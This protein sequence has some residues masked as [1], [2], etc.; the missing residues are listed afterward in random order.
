[1]PKGTKK[2][3]ANE[4]LGEIERKVKRETYT[5]PRGMPTFEKVAD[6]YL[7][8]REPDIRHSTCLGY[9]GHIKNH[10][11]PEFGHLKVNKVNFEAIEQFKQRCLKKAKK[12]TYEESEPDKARPKKPLTPA[13]VL[14]ILGTLSRI[15]TYA[16]RMGKIDHNPA[17]EVERPRGKSLHNEEDEI[18]VLQPGEIRLL[19]DAA[20]NQGERVLFVAAVLTG[21]R[22]G[23]LLGLKWGDIDWVNCQVCVRRTYNYR[24]FYKPKSKTSRRRVDLAP[25]LVSELKRW[26]LACP[27][28]DLDLVF[29]T[30]IGTPQDAT[31]MLRRQFFPALRRAGLPK[32][33]FQDLRHTYASLLIDQGEYPKYIQD[34]LGHSTI[35]LTMDIY[36]H[37]MKRV[38]RDAATKLGNTVLGTSDQAENKMVAKNGSTSG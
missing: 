16:V 20:N 15:L 13:T 8:S 35:T 11:K 23:E 5:P 9:K 38:N 25:G 24:R 29:P 2:S 31:N 30:K 34:Q 3:E 26:K 6:A 28:G 37:L 32:I 19:R 33:R 17:R 7:A 27:P 12:A 14:K 10:L 1:M 21:L 36:G 4:K 18:T 22:E